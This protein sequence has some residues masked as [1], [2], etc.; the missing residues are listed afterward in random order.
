MHVVA[1]E[2][3][4]VSQVQKN[5]CGPAALASLLAYHGANVSLEAVTKGV[6]TPALQRTLLPDMENY[7]ASLGFAAR[8]GRGDLSFLRE[9]INEGLPIVLL[10]DMGR[11]S[12]SQGHYVVV[13]GHDPNGFLMHAGTKGNV[14]LPAKELQ[15][16]WKRMNSLYL[17]LE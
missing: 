15:D 3:P 16:R 10:I 1:L 4:F 12:F 17:V 11:R 14:F 2:V 5:D 13:F 8:S 6:F 7:A 9:C